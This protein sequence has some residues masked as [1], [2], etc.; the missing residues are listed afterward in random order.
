MF[1]NFFRKIWKKNYEK[2]SWSDLKLKSYLKN[3]TGK[4]LKKSKY[5]IFSSNQGYTFT[6]YRRFYNLTVKINETFQKSKS[7]F[8]TPNQSHFNFTKFTCELNFPVKSKLI[9][10]E[11]LTITWRQN[12]IFLVKSKLF[13]SKTIQTV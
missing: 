13:T 5:Q 9:S 3:L 4:K 8:F 7:Y 1:N 11:K 10:R 12:L 2:N 6:S